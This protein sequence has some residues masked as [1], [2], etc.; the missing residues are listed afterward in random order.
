ME[1]ETQSATR[2]GRGKGKQKQQDGGPEECGR[3]FP[4]ERTLQCHQRECHDPD[5]AIKKAEGGKIVSVR[6]LTGGSALADLTSSALKYA[7]LVPSCTIFFR[8]PKGR[9]LHLIDK[10]QYPP[11]YF[12]GVTL[13]GI[14]TRLKGGMLKSEKR[15]GEWK[16][17]RDEARR[18]MQ[19]GDGTPG[20]SK[21]YGQSDDAEMD[22]L[23]E[24]LKT[25]SISLIPRAVRKKQLEKEKAERMDVAAG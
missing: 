17:K 23:T 8:T 19:L 9:R 2:T 10:H 13:H 24:G 14:E 3:T 6:S 5:A 22:A 11:S 21:E 20:E 12:F 25:T 15:E 16:E 7:C 4:D 18:K 1:I